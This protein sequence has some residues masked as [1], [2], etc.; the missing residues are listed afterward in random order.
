MRKTTVF[1][2]GLAAAMGLTATA[3]ADVIIGPS[4]AGTALGVGGVL[5]LLILISALVEGVLYLLRKF[6]KK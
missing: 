6:R 4:P 1:I 2:L 3:A 5:L